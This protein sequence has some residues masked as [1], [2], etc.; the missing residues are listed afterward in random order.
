MENFV[1]R[2][3]SAVYYECGYSCDNVLYL[4]LGSEAWFI[5]DGRYT[6]E[7]EANVRDAAV[8]EATDLLK[9][10][11]EILRRTRVKRI[12]YDPKEWHVAD[13]EKLSAKVPHIRF[14]SRPDHSHRKRIVKTPDEIALLKKAVT[15]GA[16]AFDRFA[17]Y[18]QRQGIGETEKR[19]HYAAEGILS[20]EGELALSFDPIVA[21]GPNAAKPHALPTD[22]RLRKGDL[23]LMD[24][25]VKY[26]RY[27]S[28]RTRT[29]A[30]GERPDFGLAQRF[31]DKA[32]QTAYD[33]V[34][35]A[36]DRAIERARPGMTGA[37]IDRLAREV[38][39][40]AGMGKAFVHSTGH[41][42]GL[43]I[44][45]MPYI[46]KRS[47][48]VVEEGMVFTIEP[49]VYFGGLYGIRIEDMVVMGPDGVTV[50]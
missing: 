3:E 28:D 33:T 10:A 44:H 38:I 9:T 14:V 4:N 18:L 20:R 2:S 46:A 41:G 30:V 16:E 15:L 36:H 23:L 22:D 48:T 47:D 7:A 19:L 8:V 40:E 45:E 42:V 34:R 32:V 1:L 5:T 13:F 29:I 26:H 11:R 31:G 17:D 35:K 12:V 50:L 21:V 39:E 43:D 49:G 37:Q 24:A 6:V 27:C 25:G